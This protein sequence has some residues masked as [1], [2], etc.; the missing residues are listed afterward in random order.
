MPDHSCPHLL[1]VG[2]SLALFVFCQT[3]DRLL[4][5]YRTGVCNGVEDVGAAMAPSAYSSQTS[6]TDGKEDGMPLGLA[7]TV[8]DTDWRRLEATCSG[9]SVVYENGNANKMTC[10]EMSKEKCWVGYEAYYGF[11]NKLCANNIIFCV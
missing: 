7:K 1:S 4:Q 8:L 10:T 6:R 5:L 3:P 2:T 9:E 11:S